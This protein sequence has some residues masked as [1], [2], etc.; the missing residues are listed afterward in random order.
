MFVAPSGT[1]AS[2]S[3]ASSIGGIIG[4]VF[5]ALLVL[6]F[7]IIVVLRQRRNSP[8]SANKFKTPPASLSSLPQIYDNHQSPE[9]MEL[10][11]MESKGFKTQSELYESLAQLDQASMVD[12][13]FVV[14]SEDIGVSAAGRGKPRQSARAVQ[15]RVS[16][17]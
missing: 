15:N 17:R 16:L 8:T 6:F 4:G 11:L 13:G 3:S 2:S 14:E 12:L 10:E 9:I 5:G 1:A 7:I